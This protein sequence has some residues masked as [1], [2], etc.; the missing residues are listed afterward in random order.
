MD[1]AAIINCNQAVTVKCK[2]ITKDEY[3]LHL[4]ENLELLERQIKS[5]AYKP[6]PA[7]KVEIPKEDGKTRPI[8]I[9]CYEDKLVQEALR[10]ILEAVFE[11]HA[12]TPHVRFREGYALQGAYLL[13]LH[14]N[15]STISCLFR[16]TGRRYCSGR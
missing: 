12:V 1:V 11:P 4:E 7:R 13:D 9:Y 8:S 5:K 6:R 14:G 16:S 15:A 3:G 10:R 2:S